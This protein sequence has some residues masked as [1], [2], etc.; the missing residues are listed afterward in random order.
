MAKKWH[1]V[2]HVREH[3]HLRSR[4]LASGCVFRIR[5]AIVH[6][7]HD[8]FASQKFHQ[9]HTPIMTSS[10]CEGGGE[11]FSISTPGDGRAQ[12]LPDPQTSSSG[13]L[14]S[15]QSL[16]SAAGIS[17]ASSLA[18]LAAANNQYFGHPA[19][20]T[21]SGQLHLEAMSQGLS[22]A[23]TLS[24][25]FRAEH[26]STS[27]HLAEFWMLEAEAVFPPH[28]PALLDLAEEMLKSVATRVLQ[29]CSADLDFLKSVNKRPSG[30]LELAGVGAEAADGESN[31]S[32]VG[33]SRFARITYTDAIQALQSVKG[34]ATA[35]W[36]R[37]LSTEQERWLA[38]HWARGP[39][40][41]TRYPAS[42][43]PFYMRVASDD[44]GNESRPVVECSDLL[45]P[46][47]GELMGGSLR[48]ERIDVYQRRIA[49]LGMD[50]DSSALKWYEELR[51][52]GSAPHGGYGIGLERL[53]M[54][55]TGSEHVRDVIPFPRAYKSCFA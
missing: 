36:G 34:D 32:R 44:S 46:G 35:E 21:V 55:I 52:W 7:I 40:F 14:S 24:P 13:T 38:E 1:P 19:F 29:D 45:V 15:P 54:Y 11:V 17:S 8:F 4:T 20:L 27:R 47:V 39:V 42:I 33:P 10:D 9:V 2:E 18:A 37:P 23:Y 3:P 49:E 6:A 25:C 12:P 51:R 16:P 26:S 41:V 30:V 31:L 53:V 28:L 5:S 50:K 22:R 43:K 48:E